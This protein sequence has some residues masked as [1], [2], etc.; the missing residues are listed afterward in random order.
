VLNPAAIVIEPEKIKRFDRARCN[1]Q[2]TFYRGKNGLEAKRK[3]EAAAAGKSG[4]GG[5]ADRKEN[6][7][8]GAALRPD[9]KPPTPDCEIAAGPSGAPSSVTEV[10]RG[11]MHG[12]AAQQPS[13]VSQNGTEIGPE[14]A[15]TDHPGAYRS[16]HRKVVKRPVAAI[17]REHRR[18]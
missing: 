10:L 2:T 13:G 3:A 4:G 9:I 18:N 7:G 15:S 8:A 16:Y 5:G 1:Y 12:A 6:A 14:R 17:V 11:E